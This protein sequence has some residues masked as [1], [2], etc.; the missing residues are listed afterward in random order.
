[1]I[2]QTGGLAVG[3]IST[4]SSFRRFGACHCICERDDTELL[5]FLTNQPDLGRVDLA[6]DPGCFFLGYCQF[7][8]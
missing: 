3:A 8:E 1:M 7:S 4:R 5:T 2:R 6:V